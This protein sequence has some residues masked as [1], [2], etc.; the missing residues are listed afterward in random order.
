MC[1]WNDQTGFGQC[2]LISHYFQI[3]RNFC[4]DAPQNKLCVSVNFMILE[5]TVQKLWMFKVFGQG[6]ASAGVNQQELTTCTKSG[7]QENFFYKKKGKLAL[8]RC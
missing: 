8:S 2:R 1:T 5:A 3:L 6:M 7:R 4:E